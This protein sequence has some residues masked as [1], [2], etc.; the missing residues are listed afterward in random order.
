MIV[1]KLAD[2]LI[3]WAESREPDLIVGS[4]RNPYLKRHWLFKSWLLGI[5][6]HEFRRSDDDRA[7]HDHPWPYVT[8]PLRG[9]YFEHSKDGMRVV[10]AGDTVWSFNPKRAHRV[11][12]WKDTTVKAGGVVVV[13]ERPCFTLFIR[14]PDMREWGFLCKKGWV[15][16][17]DF[18]SKSGKGNISKGCGE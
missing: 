11:E 10:N 17:K 3:P 16:W 12:L 2:I 7:L 9:M 13:T 15:H 14:G 8:H 1:A 5:Y 18:V 6:V 4:K